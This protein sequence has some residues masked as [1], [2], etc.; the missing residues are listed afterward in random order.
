MLTERQ[1]LR[2]VDTDKH[3]KTAKKDFSR[4][5]LSVSLYL[6]IQNFQLSEHPLIPTS[7]NKRRSTVLETD[8]SYIPCTK[9][10]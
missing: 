6:V 10:E 5:S 3:P 2:F 4:G 9:L 1:F 7:L 8:Q